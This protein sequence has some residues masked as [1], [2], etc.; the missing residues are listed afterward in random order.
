MYKQLC[1]AGALVLSACASDPI[2]PLDPNTDLE[3]DR[4]PQCPIGYH[5]EQS[6][7]IIIKSDEDDED[8]GRTQTEYKCV[9][10]K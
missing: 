3:R 5:I 7:S 6:T 2:D 10:D 1:I 4:V 9:P 8:K